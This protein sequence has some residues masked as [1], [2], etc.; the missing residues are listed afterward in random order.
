LTDSSDADDVD[1]AYLPAGRGF[2][3]S[4]NRQAVRA[5]CRRWAA[6]YYALDEYERERVLN[7]HTMAPTAA[8]SRRS[9][10]T[11]ATTATR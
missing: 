8:T 5:P 1:P 11:R 9:A 2:V 3:F 4:S 10:S 6:A 7:L